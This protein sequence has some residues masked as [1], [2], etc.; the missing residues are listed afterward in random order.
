[1]KRKAWLIISLFTLLFS[2]NC[3]N[4]TYDV[5]AISNV[6][7]TFID[8]VFYESDDIEFDDTFNLQNETI[9]T[10]FY[11]G[12]Y[13]FNKDEIDSNPNGWNVNESGG[14]INVINR[15]DKHS[16]V[17]E[18][19]DN[20]NTAY[21]FLE[22]ISMCQSSGTIE[23]WMRFS[24]STK[25]NNI[26]LSDGGGQT[27]S[28]YV[29][30]ENDCFNY[31]DTSVHE[32]TN[33][34]SNIWYHVRIDFEFSEDAYLGLD[35]G[36]FKIHVNHE[37]FGPYNATGSPNTLNYV[38]FTSG[39]ANSE[40]YMYLD[41]I[42]YTWE[43]IYDFTDVPVGTSGTDIDWITGG[44]DA[45]HCSI[46]AD[47]ESRKKVLKFFD[48]NG[49][50]DASM[51]F[52]NSYMTFNGEVQFWVNLND[53]SKHF[54][55]YFSDSTVSN[56]YIRFRL[57][58]IYVE[59]I[60]VLAINN[61]TWYHLKVIWFENNTWDLYV[62]GY[63][64]SN[65][66]AMSINMIDGIDR[67][68]IVGYDNDNT[69]FLYLDSISYSWEPVYNVNDNFF[70]VF[71]ITDN[72]IVAKDEFA[73][74]SDGVQYE[75]G[76][77]D[78][79][80]WEGGHVD[81]TY[82]IQD[83]ELS[84]DRN[85][86]IHCEEITANKYIRKYYDDVNDGVYN[87]T[88]NINYLWMFNIDSSYW[89]VVYSTLTDITV[90]IELIYIAPTQVALRY[91]NDIDL[92]TYTL[93]GYIDLIESDIRELTLFIGDLCYFTY[94]DAV[95]YYEV[96]FPRLTPEEKGLY[97]VSFAGNLDDTDNIQT[98]HVNNIGV[99]VNGT[100]LNNDF[101]SYSFNLDS[102][103]WYSK[104]SNIIN[105]NALGI[106]S[107]GVYSETDSE[108]LKSFYNYTNSETWNVYNYFLN[109][110]DPSLIFMTNSTI[111]ILS[112]KITGVKMTDETTIFIPDFYYGSVN[113]DESYFYVDSSNRLQFNLI[114]DD[115]NT[116]YIELRFSILT[117]TTEN[118]SIQFRSNI[119]GIST[120]YVHLAYWGFA[121]TNVYFPY[122]LTTTTSYL[123]QGYVIY[124]M[125]IIISDQDITWYDNCNGYITNLK[126]IHTPGGIGP[127][128]I[129]IIDITNLIAVLIPLIIILA[130]TL[131]LS[132]KLGKKIILPM[133]IF[134]SLLCAITNLIPIWLFFVIAIS[135][136]SLI[137]ISISSQRKGVN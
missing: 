90:V 96:V 115:N 120:G 98:I 3:L 15:L 135:C 94:K 45:S 47:W 127:I 19:Y 80:G 85:Y 72:L 62:N 119:N 14:T 56:F 95:E 77:K 128:D 74:D 38:Q 57:N 136:G 108:S 129:P 42:G 58:Y 7:Y 86:K 64:E 60:S 118:R 68:F 26:W 103:T 75:I 41:A 27:N 88:L 51:I 107:F 121:T 12:T 133:F 76:V 114:A 50:S 91:L 13:S 10:E 46:I 9:A 84:Y 30:I 132:V 44:T 33:C 112:I 117:R 25:T 79:C 102:A 89:W 81:Y 104:K 63:L 48:D 70:P 28:V 100:N 24:D 99:F 87:F 40:Y 59:D 69:K 73:F 131:V 11:N 126:L 93:I 122:S 113:I 39:T 2:F 125:S 116:E 111:S 36:T 83:P 123:P 97:E 101:A 54:R 53:A 23:L 4:L 8:N 61:N 55:F 21:S 67:V 65:N 109:M 43:A 105:V 29:Y 124:T 34:S 92:E 18:I 35:N 1:M 16:K 22:D 82:L 137:F 110:V 32:I 6:N 106:F 66:K 52:D 17:V 78:A 20:N 130:P 5:N 31:Y 49:Y 71:N 134:M 37:T